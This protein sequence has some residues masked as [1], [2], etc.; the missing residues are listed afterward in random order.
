MQDRRELIKAIVEA[1]GP[2]ID[3]KNETLKT[4]LL[5]EM[6]AAKKELRAEVASKQDIARMDQTNAKMGQDIKRVEKK[7]DE[8]LADHEIRVSQ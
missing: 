4:V 2:L 1:V 3:A 7:L 6:K 5:A 8:K